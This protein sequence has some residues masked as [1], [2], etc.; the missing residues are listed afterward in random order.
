MKKIPFFGAIPGGYECLELLAAQF[1]LNPMHHGK[2]CRG[3]RPVGQVGYGDRLG[4]WLAAA[5]EN[6]RL[7][8]G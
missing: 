1:I 3:V 4:H 6:E 8:F 7:I 2:G 5:F